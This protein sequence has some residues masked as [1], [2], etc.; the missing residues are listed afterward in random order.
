MVNSGTAGVSIDWACAGLI[1]IKLR[2]EMPMIEIRIRTML[3]DFFVPV[4]PQITIRLLPLRSILGTCCSSS[5]T[6]INQK[7]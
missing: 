5:G 2:L 7:R 4:Y 1:L 6:F 3:A